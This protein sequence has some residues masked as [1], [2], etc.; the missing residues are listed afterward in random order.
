MISES[1]RSRSFRC[2]SRD[3][4]NQKQDTE[5]KTQ[6]SDI[7]FDISGGIIK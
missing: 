1:K 4:V 2:T 3:R 6:E 5:T 7:N